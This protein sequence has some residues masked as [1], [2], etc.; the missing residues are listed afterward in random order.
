MEKE[1]DNAGLKSSHKVKGIVNNLV[2]YI[3]FADE[4]EFSTDRSVYESKFNSMPGPSV[5]SYFNEVSFNKVDV[6]SYHLPGG[7]TTNLSY[8]D[9]YTR[10]YFQTY[11]ASTNT[12]G[13]KTDSERTSRE[14]NLLSRACLFIQNNY[15]LPEGVNFDSDNNGN[16][17]NVSFIVRGNPDGWSELLWP[18]RWTLYSVP[19]LINNIKVYDY[20]FQLENTS[21]K[22]LSHEI[23]HSFGAPDLY[24]YE[25][26]SK[27]VDR[28]DI[29]ANGSGHPL[30]WTK[31]KYGGW[32]DNI[33]W[34]TKTG[35]YTLYPATSQVNNSYR[36]KPLLS[37]NQVFC[38]EFRKREG[39]YESLLPESGM[40]IYRVD[41][42]YRGNANGP[43]DEIYVFRPG[44]SPEL[45]GKVLEAAF[46]GTAGQTDFNDSTNPF[47]FLQDGSIAGIDISD[48]RYYTDS[49][50]FYVNVDAIMDLKAL[51]S[52]DSEIR[53]SWKS[54]A[55]NNYVV[56]VSSTDEILT[57]NNGTSY[58]PGDN[59]GSYGKILANSTNKSFTH[60]N[61]ESDTRFY[62]TIWSAYSDTPTTYFN[63][64]TIS[65]RSGVYTIY[66]MPHEE[67]FDGITGGTLPKGWKGTGDPISWS[68]FSNDYISAPNALLLKNQDP[69][70]EGWFYTPGFYLNATK[71]YMITF[72]Y[73]GETGLPGNITLYGGPHR[74]ESVMDLMLFEG[75]NVDFDEFALARYVYKP[76][77]NGP[78]YMG[79]NST[80]GS[81]G[82]VIEDFKIEIVPDGTSNLYKPAEFY[83]NPTSGIITVPAI[84]KTDISVYRSDGFLV[85]T[86][87]INA[88]MQ[89]DLSHLGKGVYVIKFR[90][91][92]DESLHKIIIM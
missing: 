2:I 11:D 78:I 72:R 7:A 77:A 91:S 30:A 15:P 39:L 67:N 34:I 80:Y 68:L 69:A 16:F 17:D 60:N 28:W 59:I 87:S 13:Y 40:I 9:T 55:S 10:K 43:P 42:R 47:S 33:P 84:K 52:G 25:G 58:Q 74:Y 23:F 29:M 36:I 45:E 4:S 12:E 22:T 63:P 31:S 79:F 50:T 65:S 76:L 57:L 19:V 18:H 73:K 41:Q 90:T 35:T 20:T 24:R 1:R 81:S 32:I 75:R 26:T 38:V 51:P 5:R 6:I 66:Q 44:G 82:V 46:N 49:I 89:V 71:R 14:H 85:F 37:D 21:S 92:T 83:P 62:Y 8:Q 61:L 56:A 27:P 48:I 70:S 88:T 86:K 54:N 53:L 3:R 64:T